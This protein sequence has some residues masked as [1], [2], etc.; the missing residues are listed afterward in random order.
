MFTS[1]SVFFQW[2]SSRHAE[3]EIGCYE[4]H[5]AAEDSP[6][7]F[8]H[9]GFNISII[10]SPLDC[11]R[12]HEAQVKDF[13]GSLHAD[14]VNIL[15]LYPVA[16]MI[17]NVIMGEPVARLSCTDCHGST[18]QVIEGG[19]LDPT[20]WPNTGV[21]RLNPDG[22]R[23]AC[24]ACHQRHKFS[25]AQSRRPITC[26]RCH[27]G[28]DKP[29]IHI[30][31]ESKHGISFETSEGLMNLDAR[32]WV[33]GE[34]YFAAPTCVTCHLAAAPG[35]ASTH[36]P[37]NRLTWILRHEIAERRE[38]WQ[39]NKNQMTKVCTECH[40]SDFITSWYTNFDGLLDFYDRKFGQ[41][42]QRVMSKLRET[43]KLT[44]QEFDDKIEWS[45]FQMW[46]YEAR[47]ARNA[48]AM[49]SHEYVRSGFAAVTKYF[50]LEFLPEA[51]KLNKDAVTEVLTTPEHQWY[52]AGDLITGA[53]PAESIPDLNQN[54]KVDSTDLLHFMQYWHR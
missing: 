30:Y 6:D 47:T 24:S 53:S 15:E 31:E 50:Y 17:G 44:T 9:E 54:G 20:T 22:S 4:C 38:N 7:L 49:Q 39:S 29:Q 41:P 19:R 43:G 37:A 23:G 32:K 28:H 8:I 1:A 13:D 11:A 27:A 51:K 26:G 2:S 42:A 12:C 10:V 21:G 14:A 33:V 35:L 5:Q 52:A 34:N 18:V 3:Q 45:Y 40:S 36:N 48:V 46:N 25:I 16:N